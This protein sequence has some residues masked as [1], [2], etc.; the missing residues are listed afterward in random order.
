[1]R[2]CH[3]E[4]RDALESATRYRVLD[5]ASGG[6]Y[7]LVECELDT[8]RQ[9]QIRLHLSTMGTPIVGDK[10]YGPDEELFSRGADGVLTEDDFIELEL[11]RHHAHAHT[12]R[13]PHPITRAPLEITAPLPPDLAQFWQQKRALSL[14]LPGAHPMLWVQAVMRL[15]RAADQN[16]SL[17]LIEKQR[18][19]GFAR[20]KEL[21]VARVTETEVNADRSKVRDTGA[22]RAVEFEDEGGVARGI[23]VQ[24][25]TGA[26]KAAEKW[27]T[28][29]L[30]VRC[31]PSRVVLAVPIDHLPARPRGVDVDGRK[32]VPSHCP[33][34][35]C[36]T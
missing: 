9:H 11:P 35:R 22:N 32:K 16:R 12:L 23:G 28:I 6:D 34:P 2:V 33:R 19:I 17:H 26:Q 30:R 8:G 14:M 1:M 20:R 27:L 7:A 24:A 36:N 15:K 4:D 10:L 29:A 3:A 18:R 5:T 21:V 25:K 31:V 13:L